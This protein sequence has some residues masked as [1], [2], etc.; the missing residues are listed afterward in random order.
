MKRLSV[1]LAGT[2]A[3]FAATLCTGSVASAW[4]PSAS[5]VRELGSGQAY[6]EVSAGD[7]GAGLIHAVIDI[8]APPKVVWTVMNDCRSIRRLITSAIDC[9]VVQG[10]ARTGWDIK[11]TVTKGNVF[12]P[13][14]HNIYRS[15]YQPYSLIRFRKAGGDLKVEQGEWRL[16]SLNNG[17]GTRVIYE[18]LIAANIMFPAPLVRDG[19]RK[20]TAKVLANLRRES[21]AAQSR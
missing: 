11:E 5:I 15:D 18:N 8:D 20:D 3:L 13:T 14:I 2:V 19:L 16:E 7:Q 12:I 21:L 10:D 17:A 6:S 4:A 9:H 1:S